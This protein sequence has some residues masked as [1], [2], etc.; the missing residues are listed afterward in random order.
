M[1]F[2]LLLLLAAPAFADEELAPT[3][4]ATPSL[5]RSADDGGVYHPIAVGDVLEFDVTGP[6]TLNVEV[7][8]RLPSADAAVDTVKVQAKGDGMLILTVK[9]KKGPDG[10]SILDG[11][12]GIPTRADKA[13]I[14]VP[15]GQH[16]FSLEPVDAPYPL[17]ARVT[18]LGEGGA[19]ALA[20]AKVAPVVEPVEPEVADLWREDE[21]A[22]E[23][24]VAAVEP[25]PDVAGLWGE[26]PPVEEPVVAAAEPTLE[27][28]PEVDNVWA[29]E[30]VVVDAVEDP[31]EEDDSIW[32]EDEAD[33]ESVLTS[34]EPLPTLT[35][36]EPVEDEGPGELLDAD[37]FDVEDDD[38][39]DVETLLSEDDDEIEVLDEVHEGFVPENFTPTAQ[40]EEAARHR[41]VAVRIGA[42]GAA[43]GNEAS[44]YFGL[45]GLIGLNSPATD[46]SIRLGQY[47]IG[48]TGAVAIQP[49]LGGYDGVTQE[50]DWTTR[51]RAL[52][53]GARYT[54]QDA[55]PA[56]LAPYGQVAVAGY[57][58][59]R[60]D[61]T[62]RT[63]GVAPGLGFAAGLDIPLG[64]GA[65]APE[66]AVN[67]GRGSFGNTNPEGVDAKERL[68]AWRGNLSYRYDF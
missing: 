50:I 27:P 47:A 43:A 16:I 60:I 29:T 6:V 57:W 42:G 33:L 58:S 14:T 8:Q 41:G 34:D 18:A 48:Y 53:V 49:A 63:S 3:D 15:P 11:Q 64:P 24:V 66:L 37:I 4:N 20:A 22:E 5:V 59:T 12:G 7:R 44:M 36:D 2:S 23:P 38:P 39:V 56:G 54:L 9:V 13:E 31:P 21:P 10:G 32:G 19:P 67:T 62:D 25:E 28:E 35:V 68:G 55:L 51:V 17:L 1:L 46:L 26:D 40:Q 65:L 61:G 30:D 52:E 45:E